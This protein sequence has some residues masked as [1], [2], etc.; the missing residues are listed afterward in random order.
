MSSIPLAG[1]LGYSANPYAVGYVDLAGVTVPI[2]NNATAAFNNGDLSSLD[3]VTGLPTEAGA[4][5]A[6]LSSDV[7]NAGSDFS[8]GGVPVQFQNQA[9]PESGVSGTSPTSPPAGQGTAPSA[10]TNAG[11]GITPPP[12]A[13]APPGNDKGVLLIL[14]ALAITYILGRAVLWAR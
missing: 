5:Q 4:D 14:L 1:G 8:P 9:P 6:M 13:S 7:Y 2:I 12:P 3:Q 10:S 11:Q